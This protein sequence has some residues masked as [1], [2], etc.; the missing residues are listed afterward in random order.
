MIL[1]KTILLM[2]MRETTKAEFSNCIDHF[3]DKKI[4]FKTIMYMSNVY[5]LYDI[6]KRRCNYLIE[7]SEYPEF[8]NSEDFNAMLSN[9]IYLKELLNDNYIRKNVFALFNNDYRTC[10]EA[11]VSLNLAASKFVD[12]KKE[13]VRK[14]SSWAIFGYRSF[15]FRNIFNMFVTSKYFSMVRRY[16][17]SVNENGK[18]RSINIAR[19]ILVYLNNSTDMLAPPELKEKEYISLYVLFSEMLKIC[20]KPDVIV[21]AL[22]K[23]YDLRK[24]DKWN[25]LVTFDDMITI[26]KE[27][28]SKAMDA[29]VN[30]TK[31]YQ[32]PQVK[33]T[34]AGE[35]YLTYI[36]PHFEYYCA[37]SENGRGESL[38]T[39]NSESLC[40][41]ENVSKIVMDTRNEIQTCLSQLYLFDRDVLDNISEFS[42]SNFLESKFAST[43]YSEKNGKII[44]MYHGEKVIYSCINYIDSFRFYVFFMMD[45]VLENGGFNIDVD[46]TKVFQLLPKV[47][48]ALSDYFK[49]VFVSNENGVSIIAKSKMKYSN[50]QMICFV[51]DDKVMK[52]CRVNLHMV[53]DAIKVCYN[54]ILTNEIVEY[55]RLFG[56]NDGDQSTMY[57]ALS[58]DICLLFDACISLKIIPSEYRD[59]ETEIN[60]ETGDKL[61]KN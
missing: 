45:S 16:D 50:S 51:K 48:I 59:F 24:E 11:L 5:D 38:F 37:R 3:S 14:N 46:L 15:V 34:F 49:K 12:V 8:R 53:I 20:A 56:F 36:L 60:S 31:D 2:V 55:M 21:D 9:I 7:L 25:H 6:I 13:L 35:L 27:Q 18:V 17:Y 22:W 10:I 44:Q 26:E 43:R 47:N 29:V 61:L 57:S 41:V 42:G 40:N 4:R 1:L 30:N 58:N 52:N 28:L 23:M 19:M 32:F 33:I 54:Y 39:Y